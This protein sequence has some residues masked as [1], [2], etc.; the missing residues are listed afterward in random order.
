MEKHRPDQ[1]Q[2]L[3]LGCQN[4]A[5][6]FWYHR[7]FGYK[8]AG[9]SWRHETSSSKCCCFVSLIPQ[10]NHSIKI[11]WILFSVE[12]CFIFCTD[13]QI[14]RLY[15][16]MF[17]KYIDYYY[18]WFIVLLLHILSLLYCFHYLFFLIGFLFNW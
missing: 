13:R 7:K 3:T 9:W 12:V 16:Y 17:Y 8:L 15:I 1:S 6:L 10:Y 4:I 5:T 14:N 11:Y 2:M 18:D